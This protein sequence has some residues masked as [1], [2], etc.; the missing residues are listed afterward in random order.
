MN[1]FFLFPTLLQLFEQFHFL[2]PM[3]FAVA[4]VM[5]LLMWRL[6]HREV[7]TDWQHFIDADLLDAMLLSS[8]AESWLT[9]RRLAGLMFFLSVFIL[10]GPA[11]HKQSTPLAD[12]KAPLVIALSLDQAMLEDDLQPSRLAQ[13]KLKIQ[14]LLS[15]RRGAPT[16][17]IVYAGSSHTVLPLTEDVELL[18]F[19]L[20]DLSPEIMP[21]IGDEPAQ[22]LIQALRLLQK[23]QL[24]AADAS[25]S[26]GDSLAGGSMV[27]VAAQLGS[28]QQWPIAVPRE[29]SLSLLQ[30]VGDLARQQAYVAD[31]ARG[32]NV[33]RVTIQTSDDDIDELLRNVSHHWEN[34]QANDDTVIWVDSGYYFLWLLFALMLIWFRRGMVLQW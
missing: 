33:E 29:V 11:W 4:P 26:R 18:S 25:S 15:R 24:A 17:L 1:D 10:A 20:Q 5:L 9:P 3:W 28:L 19:Y 16:A 34:L 32:L 14:S 23:T 13:A 30:T 31:Q 27:F 6:R 7:K 22:A 8:R 12:D 21:K 2:R